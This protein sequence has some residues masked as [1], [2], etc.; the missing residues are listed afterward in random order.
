VL[1]GKQNGVNHLDN[2][3]RLVHI[4]DGQIGPVAF[5]VLDDDVVS[6]HHGPQRTAA[7]RATYRGIQCACAVNKPSTN[8]IW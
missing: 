5:L 3:I 2:A 1:V 4:R 7:N 8:P 6:V